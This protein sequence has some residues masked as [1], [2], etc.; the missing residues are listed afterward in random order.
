M[1]SLICYCKSHNR[2]PIRI[3]TYPIFRDIQGQ[4]P[5]AW[6]SECGS[7]VFDRAQQTCIHCREMK[8]ASQNEK[9]LFAMYAGKRSQQ[10]RE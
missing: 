1:L 10:L 3:G 4:I 9:S 5:L 2:R 8:G 6:C 7:E